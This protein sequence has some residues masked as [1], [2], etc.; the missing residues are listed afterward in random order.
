MLLDFELGSYEYGMKRKVTQNA[1]SN[2]TGR[3]TT[4]VSLGRRI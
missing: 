3:A 4:S 2:L 1:G